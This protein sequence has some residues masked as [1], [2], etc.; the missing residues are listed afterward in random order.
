MKKKSDVVINS[1]LILEKMKEVYTRNSHGGGTESLVVV[2]FPFPFHQLV[3]FVLQ[4]GVAA[5]SS[6]Y[7]IINRSATPVYGHLEHV[8]FNL[9]MR[10]AT[11]RGYE[12]VWGLLLEG[13]APVREET[14]SPSAVPVT[15]E[16]WE[17]W[18]DADFRRVSILSFGNGWDYYDTEW[19][20]QKWESAL[21]LF[22][23]DILC[24][25]TPVYPKDLYNEKVPPG[26]VFREVERFARVKGEDVLKRKFFALH[27]LCRDPLGKQL[28]CFFHEYRGN[29]TPGQ[30][31]DALY[32]MYDKL[33]PDHYYRPFLLEKNCAVLDI[34]RRFSFKPYMLIHQF[35]SYHGMYVSKD[36][37]QLYQRDIVAGFAAHRKELHMTP[38]VP[39]HWKEPDIDVFLETELATLYDRMGHHVQ[40]IGKWHLETLLKDSLLWS[41]MRAV[42]DFIPR[43]NLNLWEKSSFRYSEF[44][45]KI[46]HE[47]RLLFDP[48][49]I[50]SMTGVQ[51][52]NFDKI[53]H[54]TKKI[55]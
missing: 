54:K 33:P 51:K 44:Q 48:K 36:F 16:P 24:L 30:I 15:L 29:E 38:Y 39:E 22:D 17:T 20:L 52:K 35:L 40:W 6:R 50:R 7:F 4:Q 27:L 34:H 9:M 19:L 28:F 8:V 12:D 11:G 1:F 18:D 53:F 42:W 23:D 26:M 55:K 49:T 43:R 13:H 37:F 5:T 45:L 31:F 32:D 25:C 3:R 41:A 14:R 46:G 2:E 10:M 21:G 47:F